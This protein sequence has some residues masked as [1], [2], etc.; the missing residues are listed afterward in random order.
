MGHVVKVFR[1]DRKDADADV[2]R[3]ATFARHV[4]S[5]R[6]DRGLFRARAATE[7]APIPSC[8]NT[9]VKVE[10]PLAVVLGAYRCVKPTSSR[11]T[12]RAT[13]DTHSRYAPVCPRDMQKSPSRP[14]PLR[15][16]LVLVIASKGCPKGQR[17]AAKGESLHVPPRAPRSRSPRSVV[18]GEHPEISTYAG[19][20][21]PTKRTFT[22]RFA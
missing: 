14:S 2:E 22:R 13:N 9:G 19:L 20:I 15:D 16:D 12:T 17:G 5:L 21:R 18:R 10:R 7:G 1:E 11:D 6:A 3:C 4:A 8:R